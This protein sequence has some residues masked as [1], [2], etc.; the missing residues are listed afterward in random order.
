M[1]HLRP[2][3]WLS[4]VA[5]DRPYNFNSKAVAIVS[6]PLQPFGL[7]INRVDH[8]PILHQ[9]GQMGGLPPW[10]ST[11]IENNLPWLGIEQG[12]N[13]LRR[14][15]FDIERPFPKSWQGGNST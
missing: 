13:Q 1:S 5:H 11:G 9:H 7:A 10:R 8:A 14:F 3:A 4:D 15:I 12:G 6:K 2:C